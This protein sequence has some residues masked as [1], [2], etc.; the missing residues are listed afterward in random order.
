MR[1]QQANELIHAW[2]GMAK[3]VPSRIDQPGHD[4]L[5]GLDAGHRPVGYGACADCHVQYRGD[6]GVRTTVLD[7]APDRLQ[8]VG[9]AFDVLEKP[10][11]VD[12]QRSG[13]VH[14]AIERGRA[15]TIWRRVSSESPADMWLE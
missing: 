9:R 14:P 5:P 1:T 13:N 15:E 12:E 7:A 10:L 4:D 6:G 3:F 2:N 8:A 11:P